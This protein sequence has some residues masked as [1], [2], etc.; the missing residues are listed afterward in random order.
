MSDLPVIRSSVRTY[1]FVDALSAALGKMTTC[2][3]FPRAGAFFPISVEGGGGLLP[4]QCSFVALPVMCDPVLFDFICSLFITVIYCDLREG[5]RRLSGSTVRQN[6][7]HQ[8][9]RSTLLTGKEGF[10]RTFALASLVIY[11]PPLQI[12]KRLI[13]QS[14]NCL[15][16]FFLWR[17]IAGLALPNNHSV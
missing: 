8:D 13:K 3:F 6:C 4:F 16:S 17:K 1:I 15:V 14:L 2:L 5:V 9:S 10:T 12:L 11:V 7:L